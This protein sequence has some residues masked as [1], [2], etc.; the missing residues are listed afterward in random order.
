MS[1][2]HLGLALLL[3]MTPAL[4]Q[5]QEPAKPASTAE[6]LKQNPND[7]AAIVAYMSEKMGLLG[8]LIDSDPAAAETMLNEMKDVLGAIEAEKDDAKELLGRARSA[9]E[10]IGTQIDAARTPKVE[11]E[12]KLRANPDDAKALMTY[13]TKVAQEISTLASSEPARAQ[14][15]LDAARKTMAGYKDAAKD[16]A[17]KS[18][19]DIMLRQLTSIEQR[20]EAEAQR[21]ELIGKDAAPLA[22]EA[23]VN[24]SPLTDA[25]LKGKVVVLDFWAV[26]CGPC[27]ATFPHLREWN[28]QYADKGLVIIGLTKYYGY[29]WDDA[30]NQAT[31]SSAKPT[32]EQERSMLEKFA[33]Q[34][35]LHHRFGIQESDAMSEFYG[36]TGIPHVVVI[37]REGV[38]RLMKV[39]S[40]E[41]N[42]QAIGSMIQVLIGPSPAAGD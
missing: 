42:A 11:L 8:P 17:S 7:V 36:V 25:D 27:I 38:V 40:G 41:A 16:A 30:N 29:T 19:I 28:E 4:A 1:R 24:G 18:R 5:A 39:G 31:R 15:E 2:Q 10:S 9:I 32:P 14:T 23:W 37:D 3:A 26:W 6:A 33:K 12:R 21:A 13:F 34:N 35:D 22:V 20:I